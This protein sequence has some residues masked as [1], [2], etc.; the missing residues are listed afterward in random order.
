MLPGRREPLSPLRSGWW[1]KELLA[2]AALLSELGCVSRLAHCPRLVFVH[3]FVCQDHYAM[4]WSS[5]W[6]ALYLNLGQLT[7]ARTNFLENQGQG[8]DGWLQDSPMTWQCQFPVAKDGFGIEAE[9]NELRLLGSFSSAPSQTNKSFP[10]CV[11]F[12]S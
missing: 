8:R 1:K 4:N 5:V 10:I 3:W 6:C 11:N 7:M 12:H 2:E 9:V